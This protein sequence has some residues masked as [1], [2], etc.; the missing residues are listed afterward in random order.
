ML[1]ESNKHNKT[2]SVAHGWQGVCAPLSG[3]GRRPARVRLAVQDEKEGGRW[4]RSVARVRSPLSCS[5]V[6]SKFLD[7]SSLR[8]QLLHQIHY[9]LK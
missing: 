3:R 5:T 2:Q 8:L 6:A 7:T 9:L 1:V 4:L